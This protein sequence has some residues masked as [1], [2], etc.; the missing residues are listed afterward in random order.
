VE[1]DV[2][3]GE[4]MATGTNYGGKFG[5]EGVGET[6]VADYSFFEE[7]ERSNSYCNLI[8]SF[9]FP[10]PH[11]VVLDYNIPFVLSKT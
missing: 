5:V 10:P 8:N 7:G 3:T 9:S 4:S 11:E 1:D 6:D 2:F